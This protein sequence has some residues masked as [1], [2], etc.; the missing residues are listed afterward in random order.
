MSQAD[1]E[2]ADLDFSLLNDAQTIVLRRGSTDVS[3]YAFVRDLN[4]QQLVDVVGQ[5][6]FHVVISPTQIYDANWPSAPNSPPDSPDPRIP[7][8]GDRVFIAGRIRTVQAVLPMY[9][10]NTLVR[11]EMKAQG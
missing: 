8:K 1:Q 11:I 7:I 6:E 5:Q 4:E 9:V 2:I 10:G 3:C